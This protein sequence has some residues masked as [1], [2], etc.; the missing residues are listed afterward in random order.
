MVLVMVVLD[1]QEEEAVVVVRQ[2][3]TAP[4]LSR[5][6]GKLIPLVLARYGSTDVVPGVRV[7][8]ASRLY[9]RLAAV[10]GAELPAL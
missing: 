5:V 6:P 10:A 4:F 1:R 2:P 8:V 3:G 9:R 7:Q